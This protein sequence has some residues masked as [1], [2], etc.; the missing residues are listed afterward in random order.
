MINPDTRATPA[1][2]ADGDPPSMA[3]LFSRLLSDATALLHNE[4]A[5][6][7]AEFVRAADNAKAAAAASAIAA[8]VLLAGV[9]ALVA[10][11]ILA[12]AEVMAPWAAALL[13]GLTFTV[14]GVVL[15]AAARRKLA[16]PSLGMERTQ[17][18]LKQDAALAA[19]KFQ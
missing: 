5:L 13:V 2:R 6:A 14:I 17:Q 11:I 15:V 9:S 19:R 1:S 3:N 8:G 18:S 4:F 10:A 7:R 12:L 16:H